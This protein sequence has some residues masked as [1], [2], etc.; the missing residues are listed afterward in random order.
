MY[1]DGEIVNWLE[2]LTIVRW[3]FVTSWKVTANWVEWVGN[4]VGKGTDFL[5]LYNWMERDC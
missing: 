4:C 3:K 5:E 1:L 2:K